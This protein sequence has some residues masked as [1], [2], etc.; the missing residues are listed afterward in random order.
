MSQQRSNQPPRGIGLLS[1]DELMLNMLLL[2]GGQR[3][4]G[5]VGELDEVDDLLDVIWG[6]HR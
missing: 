2:L 5:V 6:D 4:V 3:G 1:V